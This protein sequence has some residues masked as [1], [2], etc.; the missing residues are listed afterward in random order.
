MENI[1]FRGV[2][3]VF[4]IIINIGTM[5]SQGSE[6]Y[7]TG[8]SYMVARQFEKA[9]EEYA[10]ILIKD[11][12]DAYAFYKRG[13]AYLYMNNFDAAIAD[14]TASL[15]HGEEDP[16]SYN[17][18]GLALSYKGKIQEALD[19]FNKAIKLDAGFAQAYINR[20]S[21][22]IALN[23]YGKAIKDLDKA[24]KLDP[25]N[26]EI[27]IQRGRL[28]YSTEKY[29]KS[30]KDY[31]SAIAL[32]LANSKV[33][34]NR[35]NSY[36]KLNKFE[37]AVKDYTTAFELDPD[38]LEAL[39]NRAYTYKMMNKEEEAEKDRQLLNQKRNEQ[40]TPVDKLKFKTFTSNE[41]ELS[42]ELPE[43]WKII[44]MPQ[45]D[46]LK[47]E[48]I[49]TPEDIN[50]ASQGMTIG[51]TVGIM[52][53]LSS[54]IPV[55]SE[56]EI[57]E[58]WKGSMNMSNE[59][60]LIYKVYWQRHLQ[61]FGHAT[62]LNRSTI[63]ANENHI[64]FGLYEYAI[65]WGDNLIYLYYQAPESNFDYFEKIFEKSYQTLKISDD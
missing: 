44:E 18:R 38:D 28:Y 43:N 34:F 42:I 50:P 26:P 19:D 3:V 47:T 39:N 24:I 59:D 5:L 1:K 25:K 10:K 21:A 51:V 36:Y 61:L 56:P 11:P 14:F 54:Y 60:M 22:Y 20:G 8:D 58:F 6:I 62:I 49:I 52:K 63:Q 15:K 30:V 13:V 17:N 41:G 57:L 35:A 29:D 33:Y 12:K 32:G 27:F 55:S 16:D 48:F 7:Q 53:K 9:A 40:F 2:A 23:D 4:L 46:S 65:A 37:A 31:S 64:S 45:F